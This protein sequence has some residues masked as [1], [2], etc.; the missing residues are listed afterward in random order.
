MA[1]QD[2]SMQVEDLNLTSQATTI[3][4]AVIQS[5]ILQSASIQKE[6]ASEQPH[7]AELSAVQAA[8]G[9][10]EYRRVRCPAH[11][12]TP[13]REHWEQILTPL[14]EY[15]KLQVS[16][17]SNSD[18]RRRRRCDTRVCVMAKDERHPNVPRKPCCSW[19][20]PIFARKPRFSM[21]MWG[22]YY[23]VV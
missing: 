13:L 16:E 6:D 23:P 1:Q 9:K 12:Y 10:V 4:A 21:K 18:P 22:G 7:F 8:S 2:E 15:L 5:R 3:D 20:Q 19:T 17:H 11:R 14:V